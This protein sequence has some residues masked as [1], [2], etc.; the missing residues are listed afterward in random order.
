MKLRNI[1]LSGKIKYKFQKARN[2]RSQAS[3]IYIK[4]HIKKLERKEGREGGERK[5]GEKEGRKEEEE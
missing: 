5:E 3:S 2:L 1:Q 4:A